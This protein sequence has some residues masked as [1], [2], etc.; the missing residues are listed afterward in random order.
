MKERRQA[1][2][3]L[4]LRAALVISHLA[5]L[6]LP[7]LA[8][9][10]TG[11]LGWDLVHQ[12]RH[13]L[14]HQATIL[15]VLVRDELLEAR[16]RDPT[17]TVHDLGLD[18]RLTEIRVETLAGIRLLDARGVVAASSGDGLGEDLSGR[19][20]VVNALEGLPSAVIR[21][22]DSPARGVSLTGPS[23]R[24]KVRVFTAR[25]VVV[26]EELVG[27][28]LLNRTPREEVQALIQMAPRLSWGVLGGLLLTVLLSLYLGW[29]FS[30]SLRVLAD[31]SHRIAD[32][33]MQA[34][35]ALD[36][37]A[38]SHLAEVRELSAAV[39]TMTAQLRERLAYITEF[40][41]NVSHEFKTPISTLRGTVE[42]LREDEEMPPAQRERFLDNAQQDLERMERLVSGLLALARAE[43]AGGQ[44][45]VG[46]QDLLAAAVARH[47]D[48]VLEGRAGEVVGVPEQLEALVHNLVDNAWRHG[49]SEVAVAVAGWTEGRWTG[50]DVIDDGP[51]ISAANQQ[52]V[53]ERFFTTD[54]QAGGTGLGLALA[55]AICR[56]HGGRI[57]LESRPGRTCFRVA[58]PLAES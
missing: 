23:R 39:A 33:E 9:V 14:D 46:L 12:T 38:R 19:P 18:E 44:V 17:A 21:P 1:R 54:R 20:E 58:L 2:V 36:L 41:G 32:G 13:E 24:A 49:G 11:A 34:V 29:R 56:A 51:G 30:R 48:T 57:T 45:P 25:P 15:A 35:G 7:W 8:L 50:V 52:R 53:F 55:R 4:P 28:L 37:A 47:P 26:G 40:A 5:V 22:R 27:V 43:E 3:V 31:T 42:L 16:D 10:G 6:A